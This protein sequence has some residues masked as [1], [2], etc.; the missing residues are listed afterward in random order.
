[1][2]VANHFRCFRQKL[3]KIPRTIFQFSVLKFIYSEKA[4]KFYEIS[5]N[6][7][8]YIYTASQIIGGDFAKFCGLL[9]IY[10]LYLKR[11]EL[12]A[13][14]GSIMPQLKISQIHRELHATHNG[15]KLF[16]KQHSYFLAELCF[17]K[18]FFNFIL[19]YRR[20]SI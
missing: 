3:D 4:T 16:L 18:Y 10:E 7:L 8:S 17:S 12:Q 15:K 19:D 5:T 14:L 20:Q 11:L 9:R 6:Y 13:L 1:M 2:N